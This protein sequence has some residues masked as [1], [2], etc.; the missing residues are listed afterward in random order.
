MKMNSAA[1]AI[2]CAF[3]EE[4]TIKTILTSIHE[5]HSFEEII[6]INDGSTDQTGKIIMQLSRQIEI[7]Y[8]H[9]PENMGKGYAMAKGVEMAQSKIL[10][11]IDAD[12]SG[13]TSIHANQ[14]LSPLFNGTAFMVLGQ[15]TKTLIHSKIN[16]FKKLSGQRAT[17]K[18]DLIPVLDQMKYSRY[19][20]ETII[21]IHYKTNHLKVEYVN[22]DNL[23]HPTK[24]QKTSAVQAIREYLAEG[25]QIAK[26]LIGNN[27]IGFYPN[28]KRYA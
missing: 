15:A 19:G 18:N 9:L 22:L 28:G 4:K 8:L 11:F 20:V 26:I 14:L 6:V 5:T 27:Q 12:L 10:V 3:N 24:F 25:R 2:I 1:S 17:Y 23:Y 13:F 21:N 7:L 16:P